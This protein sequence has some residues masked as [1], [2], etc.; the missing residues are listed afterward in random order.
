MM[1]TIR[2][3]FRDT[4]GSAATEY[5]LIAGLAG[6]AIVWAIMQVGAQAAA[7]YGFLGWA[8]GPAPQ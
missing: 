7:I 8:L 6:A 1:K 5:S 4:R 2:K 3:V